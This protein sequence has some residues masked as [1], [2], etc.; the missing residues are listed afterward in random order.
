MQWV[1]FC[2]TLAAGVVAY[3]LRVNYRWLYGSSEIVVG[4]RI[5][6]IAWFPPYSY[7]A[8]IAGSVTSKFFSSFVPIFFSS[9]VPIFI[10]IYAFV[11]GCDN[12]FTSLRE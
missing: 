6:F 8:I 1:G 7:L 11:R 2:I 5:M 3:W 12:L 9:F 4:I 10:G